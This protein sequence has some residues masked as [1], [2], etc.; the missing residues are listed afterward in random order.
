MASSLQ[1]NFGFG[2]DSC[3]AVI[4]PNNVNYFSSFFGPNLAGGFTTTVNPLYTHDEI[5]KQVVASG[6]S[7]L[8][9][10]PM[11][12]P[13]V[14]PVAKE[15]DL[16]LIVFGDKAPEGATTLS[17]LIEGGDPSK[18]KTY[19]MNPRED[20]ATLP[21]SSGTTGPPKGTMCTH[22]NIVANILQSGKGEVDYLNTE[23]VIMSPLPLFHCYALVVGLCSS[24]SKGS[25]LVI[26]PSFD[27]IKF[28]ELIQ[29]QKANRIHAVPPIILGLTKHPVVD[30]V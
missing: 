23:S 3:L 30:E 8:I 27:M 20:I 18:V 15:L 11:T 28:L 24:L 6:S 1:S 12:L 2:K 4:S 26:L 17:S 5:K 16:P 29:T 22:R 21:Y 25:K 7:V 14:E 9:S 19:P 10:H 13:N